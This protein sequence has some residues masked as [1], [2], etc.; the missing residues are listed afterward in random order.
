[1]GYS[2][3]L[4]FKFLLKPKHSDA[5]CFVEEGPSRLL[6]GGA[7]GEDAR[8][9][10]FKLDNGEVLEYQVFVK[11]DRVSPFDLAASWRAYQDN[12]R[13]SAARWIP[14]VS[15]NSAPQ[16]GGEV[17]PKFQFSFCSFACQRD[18]EWYFKLTITLFF[19]FRMVVLQGWNLILS[20][21]LSQLPQ[22][23]PMYMQLT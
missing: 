15:I 11:A 20:I 14:D 17:K 12:F 2:E 5:P 1:V 7:L 10:L 16:T 23:Q 8:L 6:I 9:A 18:R 22:H 4:D 13:P 3:T 21:M 19:L